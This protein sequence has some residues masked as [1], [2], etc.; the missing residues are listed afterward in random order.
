[1]KT[2]F[3]I[4]LK[5]ICLGYAFFGLSIFLA[6][7]SQSDTNVIE[8][9]IVLQTKT[10]EIHG[11]LTTPVKFDKIPVA[12][13]IAGSG[14]TDRDG[15][16][17]MM[18]NNSLKLLSEGLIAN[19]IASLR[20][21][22]RAIAESAAAGPSEANLRFEDYINDAKD[23]IELLRKDKRFSSVIV[24]GHSEG[25]LI[26]M[27]AAV[28]ADKYV[29]IAGAGQSAD[30]ILKIQLSAQ[31]KFVQDQSLP[32]ID[33]LKNGLLVSHVTPILASLFR[34]SIQPYLISW[35]KYDPQEEIKKLSIPILIL[36]GTS[37]I[38]ISSEDAQLLHSANS[39]S[40]LVFIEN[41]NHI[42]KLVEGNREM[43]IKTYNNPDL[44]I[45]DKL[46]RVIADFI[47]K[48]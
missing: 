5:V 28:S 9:K 44:P 13:I 24:I 40:K 15:N 17:S 14:P 4:F 21:D 32:V 16:N 19:G 30:K 45:A 25:S 38:Q 8:S 12:L 6:E 47:L 37:D 20:Y 33:S 31:P 29:S 1:M 11:T 7:A 23:W 27:V 36:Q 26:G 10:G 34:P 3:K 43:N 39:K 42:F 22:K 46:V 18:K 2:F 41:M 48:K 35:F